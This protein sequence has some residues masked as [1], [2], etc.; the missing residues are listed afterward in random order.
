M[1]DRQ[2]FALLF[3]VGLPFALAAIGLGLFTLKEL[4]FRAKF[5]DALDQGE[6]MKIVKN[7]NAFGISSFDL[8]EYYHVNRT[9][10]VMQAR[11]AGFK[12]TGYDNIC[13]WYDSSKE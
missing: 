6:L 1:D 8:A 10:L 9:W 2:L 13:V 5:L 12:V 3:C 4:Y 7:S 11:I